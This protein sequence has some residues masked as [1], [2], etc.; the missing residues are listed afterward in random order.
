MQKEVLK[1]LQDLHRLEAQVRHPQVQYVEFV[2]ARDCVLLAEGQEQ[3]CIHM[4]EQKAVH[5][6]LAMA[7][8]NALIV[9]A[10]GD[11]KI[12]VVS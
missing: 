9:E 3:V 10:L 11:S 12:F 4:E 6:L 7:Q 1:V 2:K 8:G 5:A